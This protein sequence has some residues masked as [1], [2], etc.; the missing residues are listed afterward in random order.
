M[1]GC[2]DAVVTAELSSLTSLSSSTDDERLNRSLHRTFDAP[3]GSTPLSCCTQSAIDAYLCSLRSRRQIPA[4]L[5]P[6]MLDRGFLWG[7]ANSSL[8]IGKF[9]GRFALL[10]FLSTTASAKP[11]RYRLPAETLLGWEWRPAFHSLGLASCDGASAWIQADVCGVERKDASA[12]PRAAAIGSTLLS[13]PLSAGVAQNPQARLLHALGRGSSSA[14]GLWW[15]GQLVRSILFRPGLCGE[16]AVS[17]LKQFVTMTVRP[18]AKRRAVP[19]GG[20]PNATLQSYRPRD[21][22]VSVTSKS[23]LAAPV[24][25]K[26]CPPP[27]A[28]SSPPP[29]G[30]AACVIAVHVR[31]GDA[32]ERYA[33]PGDGRVRRAGGVGKWSP[34][35]ITTLPS[36]CPSLLPLPS[37]PYPPPLR[38]LSSVCAFLSRRFI[39]RVNDASINGT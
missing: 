25:P 13:S 16:A 12:V 6:G 26:A 17:E 35:A 23:T 3:H 38:S 27:H 37:S 34:H 29:N 1:E 21:L 20:D 36:R 22:I 15:S 28:P 24:T 39:R 32:C 19:F 2:T 5:A 7:N 14:L 31:R 9:I 30:D 11:F 33:D 4:A 18:G 10:M 8:T